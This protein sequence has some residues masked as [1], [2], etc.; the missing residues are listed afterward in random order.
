MKTIPFNELHKLAFDIHRIMILPQYWE[1][2]ESFTMPPNGRPD[3]GIMLMVDCAFEYIGADKQVCDRALPGQLVYSP[4]G[5]KYTCRF[6]PRTNVKQSGY[7][8]DYLI[9]FLL[10]DEQGEELRLAEDR[11][12]ITPRSSRYYL[13]AFRNID[14]LVRKGL[15]PSARV[16]GLLYNLLCDISLELQEHDI[17][18]RSYAAI[19]P[20]IE[21]I[22][23]TDLA[24]LDTAGLAERCHIS[25]SCFRRLFREYTGMPPREYINHLK[26]TQ[27]R[28]LLQSGAMTVA[29]V[30]EALGFSDPAYFSRFYKRETGH[31]PRCVAR[32]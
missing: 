1:P 7:V 14:S 20:A 22:R 23:E 32:R 26:V 31:S 3:N 17:L 5:S 16:K 12:I 6:L 27:A 25:E 8:A 2:G 13:D 29:E 28:A 30:A 4:K 21:Y 15:S 24:Q 18:T 11:M 19:Y 9:N 10:L